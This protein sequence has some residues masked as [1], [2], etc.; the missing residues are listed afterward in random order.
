MMSYDVIVIGGGIAGLSAAAFLSEA[1]KVAVIEAEPHIGYHS[2]GRSAAIF[3]RNYGNETLR[4]LND[5]A[6][7]FF[8]T[9]TQTLTDP[10]LSPRGELLIAKPDEL[11]A[12][13]AYCAGA[14][15]LERLNAQEAC[16]LVPILNPELISA[17][18]YE[19]DAQ[20]IDVDRLLQRY[21]AVMRANGGQIITGQ[22]V[23][24]MAKMGAIWTITTDLDRYQAPVIINASGAWGDHIGQMAGLRPLGLQP[25]RRSAVIMA[26]PDKM[27][28][29]HWPL[30]GSI[31]EDWYAKPD[32]GRLMI[33]PAD[34]DPIAPQDAYPDDLVLAQGLYRFEQATTIPVTRPLR[35]WAGLRSFLPDHTPAVGFDPEVGGFFWLI[36][37]GGYG[38]QT[39]PALGQLTRDLVLAQTSVLSEPIIA[40]LSPN[41]F[42]A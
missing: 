29:A 3:I 13:D 21:A 23:Q 7:R 2:T 8:E 24:G 38:V 33:S 25:Y 17:A 6:A 5:V 18:V 27:T 42:H 41:R 28:C 20:D 10:V 9:D 16:D 36:G 30:F 12:L 14:T 31:N 35:S 34:A 26:V 37:Q 22:P 39:S 19:P 11:D 40:A 32:A 15:G 4:A 1:A